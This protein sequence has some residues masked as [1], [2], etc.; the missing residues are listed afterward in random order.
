MPSVDNRPILH[1]TD[2]KFEKCKGV[3]V[4]CI[5]PH[6]DL[7]RNYDPLNI[8]FSQTSNISTFMSV[9]IIFIKDLIFPVQRLKIFKCR[10]I[11]KFGAKMSTLQQYLGLIVQ[12]WSCSAFVI[13]LSKLRLT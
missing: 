4:L 10:K 12:S 5:E 3:N 11:L 1:A 9:S 13:V 7:R 2:V 6:V 8:A